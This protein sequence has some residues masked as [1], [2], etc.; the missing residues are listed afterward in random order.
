MTPRSI[1]LDVRRCACSSLARGTIT[2]FASEGT[3]SNPSS[4]NPSAMNRRPR[5][6]SAS[7]RCR[8]S[9]SAKRGDSRC[10]RYR[11]RL[12][13][14]LH[15]QQIPDQLLMRE[16]VADANARE[17]VNLRKRAQRDHVVVAVVHRVRI[18]R[19][20]A[21]VFEIRLVQNHQHALRHLLVERVELLLS[22][23]RAGGVIRIREIDDLGLIVDLAR[24][25]F[26]IVVPVA[27]RARC[28]TGR[29]AISRAP[30]TR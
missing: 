11:A 10:L 7:E 15:L 12:E 4:R 30:G 16:A 2:K 18:T 6:F 20:V 24:Q 5:A 14:Q 21:R 28:D 29:R 3:T 13:R 26:E 23:D 27:I 22:E 17:S 25:R 1:R 8:N 19:V 9:L